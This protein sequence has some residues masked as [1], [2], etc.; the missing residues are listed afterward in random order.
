MIAY[1]HIFFDLNVSKLQS[2]SV[3]VIFLGYYDYE[4]YK[5]L[6]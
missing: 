6:E 4:S 5:L 2:R 3:K 1:T